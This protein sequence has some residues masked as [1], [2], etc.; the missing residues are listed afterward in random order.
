MAS[1]CQPRLILPIPLCSQDP[2]RCLNTAMA[3]CVHLLRV[4]AAPFGNARPSWLCPRWRLT[5]GLCAIL[6]FSRP[7]ESC[8]APDTLCGREL[9]TD[10][11]FQCHDQTQERVS[12]QCPR[13]YLAWCRKANMHTGRRE[14]LNLST[15]G[16]R[17]RAFPVCVLRYKWETNLCAPPVA[18]GHGLPGQSSR[19][20]VE[21]EDLGLSH[22]GAQEWRVIESPLPRHQRGSG[23]GAELFSDDMCPGRQTET[24]PF[25]CACQQTENKSLKGPGEEASPD[26]ATSHIQSL[27]TI[28]LCASNTNL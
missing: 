17:I 25:P 6:F 27:I 7:P 3:Y 2:S 13:L 12:S 5:M 15:R 24:W 23:E 9:F 1:H 10:S 11:I 19:S 14:L 8:K 21:Q 28:S 16:W 22:H 18:H 4:T 20:L 26:S